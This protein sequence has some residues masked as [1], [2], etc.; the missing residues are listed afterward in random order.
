MSGHNNHIKVIKP[1]NQF[2]LV[3]TVSPTPKR[4]DSLSSREEE[5]LEGDNWKNKQKNFRI[6]LKEELKDENSENLGSDGVSNVDSKDGNSSLI[7]N[8]EEEFM[9]Q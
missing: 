1:K 7:Q 2:N 5:G 3:A 9:H 8:L 4:I 6:D